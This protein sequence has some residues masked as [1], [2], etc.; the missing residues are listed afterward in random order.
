MPRP[1]RGNLRKKRNAHI[2]EAE[3]ELFSSEKTQIQSEETLTTNL[4][5]LYK[6]LGGGWPCYV[7]P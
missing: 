5:S 6:S 2:P 3:K 1:K 7:S 4:I